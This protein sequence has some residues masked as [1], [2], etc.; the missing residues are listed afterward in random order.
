MQAPRGHR[1]VCD[2]PLA[3]HVPAQV[4]AG[5][6]DDPHRALLPRRTPLWLLPA[7]NGKAAPRAWR[8]RRHCHVPEGRLLK[9]QH[10]CAGY[11][12]DVMHWHPPPL[13]TPACRSWL[14]RMPSSRRW[15]CP[16]PWASSSQPGWVPSSARRL[17]QGG[18]LCVSTQCRSAS[19]A[20]ASAE[21]TAAHVPRPRRHCLP[22]W[23]PP[24]CRSRGATAASTFTSEATSLGGASSR[25]SSPSW[26][27]PWWVVPAAVPECS[28]LA[29]WSCGVGG[30]RRG[31][32][33][34]ARP[35]P[36]LACRDLL[37]SAT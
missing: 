32:Q 1:A 25:R 23:R 18:V 4:R 22:T 26:S 27:G 21:Q 19:S 28:V 36:A 11:Q 35:L 2:L 6:H 33:L 31:A 34:A 8:A 30:D 20:S 9:A 13:P 16:R 12:R 10:A 3:G 37:T 15:C 17:L 24:A 5:P 14:S 7:H 29:A